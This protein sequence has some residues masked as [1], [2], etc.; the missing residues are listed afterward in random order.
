MKKWEYRILEVSMDLND[1]DEN[2]VNNLGKE[3]WEMI[4][5]TPIIKDTVSGGSYTSSVIFTLK[6]ELE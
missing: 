4:S 2:E 3:G 1:N 6:R 5:V